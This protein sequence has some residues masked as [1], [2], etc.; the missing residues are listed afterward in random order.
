MTNFYLLSCCREN[1]LSVFLVREAT[2]RGGVL[3]LLTL[4]SGL[5]SLIWRLPIT[6]N[7]DLKATGTALVRM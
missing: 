2:S 1:L 6:F 3:V 4:S 5:T 7:F